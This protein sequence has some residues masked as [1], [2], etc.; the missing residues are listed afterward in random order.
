[1]IETD[2]A[3]A[4]IHANSESFDPKAELSFKYLQVKQLADCPPFLLKRCANMLHS[5]TPHV[6]NAL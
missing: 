1:V 5:V 2:A 6:F 4:E 3:I